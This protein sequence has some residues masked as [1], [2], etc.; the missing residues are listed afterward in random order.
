MDTIEVG[1]PIVPPPSRPVNHRKA[2]HEEIALSFDWRGVEM[3]AH[4]WSGPG[5]DGV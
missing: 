2:R 1:R 5:E 4:R 3:P